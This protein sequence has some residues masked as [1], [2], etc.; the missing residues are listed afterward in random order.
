MWDALKRIVYDTHVSSYMDLDIQMS[1]DAATIN[2]TTKILENACASPCRI[3]VMH[4]SIQMG[5]I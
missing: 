5:A 1:I 3:G 2:T 4:E